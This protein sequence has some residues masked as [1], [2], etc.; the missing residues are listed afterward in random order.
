MVWATA[1]A[2]GPP[3]PSH[4]VYLG[5]RGGPHLTFGR[6]DLNEKEPKR[7]PGLVGG[8]AAV[9]L[10]GQP[11]W[12]MGLE[13][14]VTY[15]GYESD[16]GGLNHAL[17]YDLGLRF[18]PYRAAWQLYLGAG[19]G[20]WQ[21]VAGNHGSDADY[22]AHTVLGVRGMLTE[23]VA[24]DIHVRH[25]MVDSL[26]PDALVAHNLIFAV[27]IDG[28]LW[29]DRPSPPR[30]PDR[31]GD[32]VLDR[33]DACPDVP[34]RRALRGC[35]D[36]DRDGVADRQ[37][38]CPD[39]PGPKTLRGCPDTDGDGIADP[40]DQCP[41]DRGKAVH[42]GCPDSDGDGLAD[43][44]DQ[45]PEKPGPAALRGCP[46][47]MFDGV[48]E[49]ILFKTGRASIH[50]KSRPVL[51]RA[52]A[53]LR[54]YPTLRI[55]IEG[56]TDNRASHRKNQKL[57]EQRA[58]AVKAYLVSRGIAAERIDAVG[59]GETRPIASNTSKSGRNRNR[60]IELHVAR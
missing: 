46:P 22:T 48:L 52:A 7:E 54:Q 55:R 56:H 34:G 44:D 37:D 36:R 13:A 3:P 5:V 27:G 8:T 39:A 4:S 32:G 19:G 2:A 43:G 28:L 12:W 21:N 41:T 31:D 18:Y 17:Y 58:L 26:D 45:C 40:D 60:R 10:G 29:R 35:P 53:A 30:P 20:I 33:D 51:D 1:A 24:L 50:R 47:K 23:R 59:Y 14:G 15:L 57:S 49:G 38:R 9:V 25:Y 6:F 16:L 11:I 42:R